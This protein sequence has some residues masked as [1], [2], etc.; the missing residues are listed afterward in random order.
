[1]IQSNSNS[2]VGVYQVKLK[3]TVINEDSSTLVNESI[4][5][6]LTVIKNI[7]SPVINNDT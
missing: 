2:D 7:I 3:A 6:Q 5:W 4:I 1:M